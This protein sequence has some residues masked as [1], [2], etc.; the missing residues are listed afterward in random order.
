MGQSFLDC[1]N[2]A[3]ERSRTGC[4]I[5]VSSQW[6]FGQFRSEGDSE[7]DMCISNLPSD[8]TWSSHSPFSHFQFCFFFPFFNF[9]SSKS[10]NRADSARREIQ[11]DQR[12]AILLLLFSKNSEVEVDWYSPSPERSTG[13]YPSN[14]AVENKRQMY[15]TSEVDIPADL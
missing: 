10:Q 3:S 8:Q 7:N 12:R 14:C 4:P 1:T 15:E 9:F 2:S 5:H 11:M 6:P 13:R